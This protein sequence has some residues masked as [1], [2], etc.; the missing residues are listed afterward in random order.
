MVLPWNTE[1][2]DGDSAQ[3]RMQ[4]CFVVGGQL[5]FFPHS[6]LDFHRIMSTPLPG[7]EMD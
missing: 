5:Q 1:E 3:K 7:I 6:L 2:M 4:D